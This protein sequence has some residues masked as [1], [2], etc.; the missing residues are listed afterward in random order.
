MAVEAET[1]AR[2]DDGRARRRANLFIAAF[3]LSQILIPLRYYLG[4]GG[5]DER[6]SWR[7]FSSVRLHRCAVEVRETRHG[8]STR[9]SLQREVQVAW[10]NMLKRYRPQVVEAFLASRCAKEAVER[11]RFDRQCVDTDG[12]RL[13]SQSLRLDCGTGELLRTGGK[14]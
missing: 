4:D 11:V 14:P 5:Y 12:T 8:Q 7:M 1:Q 3:L 6:F 13:P 2:M 10:V 9:L